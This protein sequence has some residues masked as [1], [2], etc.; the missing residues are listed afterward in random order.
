MVRHEILVLICVGS[1]PTTLV[2]IRGIIL[3]HAYTKRIFN[4]R[5]ILRRH[6]HKVMTNPDES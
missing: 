6:R 4:L 1:S 2:N 5:A 3:D